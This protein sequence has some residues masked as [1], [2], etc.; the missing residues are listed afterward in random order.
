VVEVVVLKPPEEPVLMVV[1][2]AV[3]VTAQQEVLLLQTQEAEGEVLEITEA[4]IQL[5][6][7]AVQASLLS[8]FLTTSR[9]PSQAVL[10]PRSQLRYQALTSTP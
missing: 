10:L 5:V 6:A 3:R 4:P 1:E 9:L 7:T 8:R 2:M